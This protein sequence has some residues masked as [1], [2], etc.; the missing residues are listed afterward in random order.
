M[1]DIDYDGACCSNILVNNK[2][3]SDVSTSKMCRSYEKLLKEALD[4]LH[5]IQ[6]IKR[7]LQKVTYTSQTSA[8]GVESHLSQ[9]D[10]DTAVC[11]AW[12]LVTTKNHTDKSKQHTISNT[13]E[14]D[15]FI[16]TANQ[17]FPL[18]EIPTD[19]VAISVVVNGD[20]STKGSTK[21][22]N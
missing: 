19:E 8:R 12:S 3:D 14:T 22:T 7:F 16:R 1:A 13:T 4:E 18:T 11:S 9:K 5:S 6:T 2:G 20:I 15:Q 21:A 10:S 17:Y